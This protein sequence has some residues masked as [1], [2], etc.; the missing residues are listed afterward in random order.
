MSV[1]FKLLYIWIVRSWC[2]L[3]WI[4]LKEVMM[5]SVCGLSMLS[6]R[7]EFITD[8]IARNQASLLYNCRPIPSDHRDP[9][10]CHVWG[11]P[12]F[13]LEPNLQND[14]KL[15]KWNQRARMGQ[16]LGFLDDHYFL[17]ANVCHLSTG[18]NSP[19]F[20]LVFNY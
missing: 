8:C 5:I 10:R 1:K 9:L 11:C 13:D 18:Y 7:F 19:Q 3:I 4:S 15:P 16:F 12:I 6:I 14:Q 2:M 20:H 17:V